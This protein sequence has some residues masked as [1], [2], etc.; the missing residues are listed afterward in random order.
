MLSTSCLVFNNASA[1]TCFIKTAEKQPALYIRCH[2][3]RHK[4]LGRFKHLGY[5]A[6]TLAVGCERQ[7]LQDKSDISKNNLKK[8]IKKIEDTPSFRAPLK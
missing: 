5:Y 4:I 8:N 7:P 1:L 6:I 2:I 3:D